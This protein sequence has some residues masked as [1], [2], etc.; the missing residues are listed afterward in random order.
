[1]IWAVASINASR[2][3][4]RPTRGCSSAARRIMKAD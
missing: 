4:S 3:A 1:M 2:V